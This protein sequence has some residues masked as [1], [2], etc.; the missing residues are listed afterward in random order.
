M[1]REMKNKCKHSKKKRSLTV[2]EQC[3]GLTTTFEIR[4][5]SY[6]STGVAKDTDSSFKGK[7]I[8]GN[9]SYHTASYCFDLNIKLVMGT[10]ASGIGASNMDQ[11]L[12]F[13]DIPN[14]KSLHQ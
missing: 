8:R 11:L 2:N 10:F 5:S 1:L 14:A 9:T 3:N 4:C 7:N 13:M 12:S 6:E